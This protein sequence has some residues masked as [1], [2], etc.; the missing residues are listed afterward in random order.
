[1][2][3]SRA[4]IRVSI[5]LARVCPKASAA[6]V[7]TGSGCVVQ[8]MDADALSMAGCYSLSGRVTL[9]YRPS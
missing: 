3:F 9:F 8:T 6:L 1:M 4:H 7:K 2:P 5:L